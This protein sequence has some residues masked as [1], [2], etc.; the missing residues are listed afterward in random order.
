[1][2]KTTFYL[3][4]M[5]EKLYF[6]LIISLFLLIPLVKTCKNKAN[7]VAGPLGLAF[8]INTLF[9]ND[10]YSMQMVNVCTQ[11]TFLLNI[12]SKVIWQSPDCI[13]W[14]IAPNYQFELYAAFYVSYKDV[15]F[16]F[17]AVKFNRTSQNRLES[18]SSDPRPSLC[19]CVC[20][21]VWDSCIWRETEAD[22]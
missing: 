4:E 17:H 14:F 20:V 5:H 19:V 21:C 10:C 11:D 15:S 16:F 7:S 6:Y 22:A 18:W 9:D 2:I 8:S 13:I 1:M 3:L 12:K